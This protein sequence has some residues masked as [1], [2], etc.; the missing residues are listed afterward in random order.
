MGGWVRSDGD[1]GGEGL[2]SGS[3]GGPQACVVG[4]HKSCGDG[5]A[6]CGEEGVVEAVDVE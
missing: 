4:G 2:G 1:G 6:E 5:A 3:G